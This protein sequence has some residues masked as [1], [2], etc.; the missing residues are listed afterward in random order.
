MDLL[1]LDSSTYYPTGIF[2]GYTSLIWTER[3]GSCG[4]FSLK[5]SSISTTIERLPIGSFISLRDSTE[6]MI[7]ETHNVEQNSSGLPELTVSGRSLESFLENRV[8][9]PIIH[10]ESWTVLDQYTPQQMIGLHIWNAMVNDSGEDPMKTAMINAPHLAAQNLVVSLS[11]NQVLPEV[12]WTISPTT[13]DQAIRDIQ[14]TFNIGVRTVRPGTEI[15]VPYHKITFDVS[16]TQTRG[17]ISI[18]LVTDDSINMRFDVY[19]GTDRS[20]NQS[21]VNPVIFQSASGHLLKQTHLK[22][23]KLAKDYV[24]IYR[25]NGGYIRVPSYY[26]DP[27][28]PFDPNKVGFQ[29]RVM[30]LDGGSETET[31]L[32]AK[33]EIELSKN[34]IISMAGGEASLNSPYK[35]NQDYFLGDTITFAGNYEP[36]ISMFVNE[37][38]R[39]EDVDGETI[40]PGLTAV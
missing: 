35:Y 8:L 26:Y 18:E 15:S 27:G 32:I 9:T 31:T 25:S 29:R 17:L 23:N 5:T 11:N 20:I 22:S 36:E 14:D 2:E 4:E 40:S 16:R 28:E 21:V 3:F 38:V 19:Q 39:T 1:P 34:K 30:S 24:V 6:V 13:V 12:T 10:G 33:A 37:I 7:V